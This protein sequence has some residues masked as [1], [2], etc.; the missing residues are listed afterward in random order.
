MKR[1]WRREASAKRLDRMCWLTPGFGFRDSERVRFRTIALNPG[2][3]PCPPLK[4][5]WLASFRLTPPRG[6]RQG[7]QE[8]EMMLGI[9]SSVSLQSHRLAATPSPSRPSSSLG[10]R[11][12]PTRRS[13]WGGEPI[14]H[15]GWSHLPDAAPRKGGLALG[16]KAALRAWS[17]SSIAPEGK[18]GV[19]G[20]P[21]RVSA[22]HELT[23]QVLLRVGR[24][25]NRQ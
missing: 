8:V 19:E 22:K 16:A 15:A 18:V 5:A 14:P 20:P 6:E 2:R 11:P 12:I 1:A 23:K 4:G 24:M 25:D 9:I 3:S 17:V 10:G 21:Q 7:F 13:A